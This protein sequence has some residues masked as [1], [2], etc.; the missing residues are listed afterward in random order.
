MESVTIIDVIGLLL[1]LG[2][3]IVGAIKGAARFVVGLLA[4]MLGLALA[5]R[6]G[7]ALGAE[8]WPLIADAEDPA[9]V[10]TL[11]GSGLIFVGALLAGWL[12]ARLLR[13][14]LESASLGGIDRFLGFVFGAA[15]GAL[16]CMVIVFVLRTLDVESFRADVDASYALKVTRQAAALTRPYTPDNTRAVMDSALDIDGSWEADGAR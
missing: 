14:L 11:A 9:A 10:G 13:K 16:F 4:V 15:R 5:S 7:G 12:I 3:G 8:S 6:Y 1:I 2:L